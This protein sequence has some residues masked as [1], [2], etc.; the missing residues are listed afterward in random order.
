MSLPHEIKLD[1]KL[2]QGDAREIARLWVTHRGPATVF[3]APGHLADP[4]MFG[5]LLV[6][7]ARHAAR[8]YAQ[9]LGLS[10]EEALQRLL[11]GFDAERGT[12]TSALSTP[13]DR[14]DRH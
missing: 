12:P 8:A 7:T 1:P 5:M 4:A 3:L 10:E 14:K 9:A 2:L 11:L 6:D 13:D